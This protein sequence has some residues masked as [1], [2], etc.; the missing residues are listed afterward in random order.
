M[1][2]EVL[3]VSRSGYYA[4]LP[5]RQRLKDSHNR[6]KKAVFG[7][8]ID[9]KRVYGS[10]RIVRDLKE[11]EGLCV[12]RTQVQ[13]V[14]R[15]LSLSSSYQ[16][17]RFRRVKMKDEG[18]VYPSNILN[19]QF[20]P[21]EPDKVYGS[22]VTFLKSREGWVYL[23]VVMDLFS[24]MIIGWSMGRKHDSK[25]VQKALNSALNRRSYP[26]GVLFHSDRG[27]EYS[28]FQIQSFLKHHGLL[29]SMSRT[30]NCWDNA[31]LESFFKTLKVELINGIH[32]RKLD[33]EEIKKECFNYIEG[34]YN[35]RRI[36]SS[37]DNKSPLIYEQ[38]YSK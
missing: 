4:W 2:C 18:V 15:D 3:Q 38:T 17:K 23:C 32:S 26:K 30:G 27:S 11:K 13:P 21:T 28:S 9:S 35:T 37:L 16:K 12:S 14:M 33:L 25:L 19:R 7:S 31:P 5:H 22:D 10:R 36:H 8:W 34:F 29:V 24:K 20:Q 6:L 1:I